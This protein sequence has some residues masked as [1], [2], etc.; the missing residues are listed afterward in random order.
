MTTANKSRA[1]A[2]TTHTCSQHVVCEFTLTI[3]LVHMYVCTHLITYIHMY[4]LHIYVM[5]VHTYVRMYVCSLKRSSREADAL[6]FGKEKIMISTYV[7]ICMYIFNLFI[8]LSRVSCC[9]PDFFRR[10]KRKHESHTSAIQ[11]CDQFGQ[12]RRVKNRAAVALAR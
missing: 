9:L 12:L 11:V 5:Y 8:Y 6:T 3:I 10:R 4:V 1:T 7:C 2:F